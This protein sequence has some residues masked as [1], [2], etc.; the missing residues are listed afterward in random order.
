M[1]R[2]IV[3]YEVKPDRVEENLALVRAVYEELHSSR[4][5]G[6]SYATFQLDDDVTFVHVAATTEDA[7]GNPLT[8]L[9]AFKRFQTGI[10]DRCEV[11]PV[12]L[13]ARTVGSYGGGEAQ[14]FGA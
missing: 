11:L 3:R 12:V 7:V 8:G 2:T 4:P 6:L 1:A 5:D 10:A 9:A 14:L 13:P